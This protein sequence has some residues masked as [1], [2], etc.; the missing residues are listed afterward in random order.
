M[1]A[2][3]FLVV[4]FSCEACGDILKKPKLDQHAGRCRGAYYTCIDCNT[5]F[6]GP[7]GPQGYRGHTSCISEE[8]KYQKSVY[9]EPK[10]KKNKTKPSPATAAPAVEAT[11]TAVPEPVSNADDARPNK[12]QREEEEPV[13]EENGR[14]VVAQGGDDDVKTGESA[15]GGEGEDKKSKKD[16]KKD[17]KNKKAK[18]EGDATTTTSTTAAAVEPTG[19]SV[20]EFLAST[21]STLLSDSISLADLRSKVVDSAKAQGFE[22]AQLEEVETQLWQGVKVGG[23]KSKVKYEFA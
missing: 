11:P 20:S 10:G 16:K 12:R 8:Q 3:I 14:A 23:K 17:K 15:A 5:T 19:P 7:T 6:E 22:G 2:E 4:S 9:K 1:R 18:T 21:V 13:V